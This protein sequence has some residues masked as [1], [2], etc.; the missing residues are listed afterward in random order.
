MEL[1]LL[2]NF[3]MTLKCEDY[4]RL[5][6]RAQ[7]NDKGPYK[8]EAGISERGDM[9]TEADTLQRWRKGP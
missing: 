7:C 4:S 1:K 9:M 6:G 5:S 2:T 8:S 3:E